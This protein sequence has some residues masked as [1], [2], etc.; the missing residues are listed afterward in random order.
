M[1]IFFTQDPNFL[2]S[3]TKGFSPSAMFSYLFN[4]K[5]LFKKVFPPTNPIVKFHVTGNT[6][7][8]FWPSTCTCNYCMYSDTDITS[9]YQLYLYRE[10][11]QWFSGSVHD[12]F[13]SERSLV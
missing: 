12:S 7:F 1:T 4:V 9:P 8:F 3:F 5:K 11:D 2:G 13:K 10:E 6:H